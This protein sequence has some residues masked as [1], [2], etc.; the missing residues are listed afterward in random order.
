KIFSNTGNSPTCDGPSIDRRSVQCNTPLCCAWA[1]WGPPQY[2]QC[3]K[4]CGGGIMYST[5]YRTKTFGN[6]GNS[7][8][9]DGLSVD[10]RSVSCNNCPCI[11]WGP[12]TDWNC[13][14]CVHVN[15]SQPYDEIQDPDN[16]HDPDN[17]YDPDN[18]NEHSKCFKGTRTCKRTRECPP[19]TFPPLPC[20]EPT[21]ETNV[22]RGVTGNMTLL[23][24]GAASMGPGINRFKTT[25]TNVRR[26]Q[27][28]WK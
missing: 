9:C 7:Q 4:T 25:F 1:S 8:T 23:H 28:V 19:C 17:G 10:R 22:L 26:S 20:P 5:R 18:G 16:G 11:P 6:T 27:M 2:G 13:T 14:E 3:S 21:S 15:E 12:W 24:H